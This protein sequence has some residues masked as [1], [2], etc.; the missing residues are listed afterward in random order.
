M[1]LLTALAVPERLAGL[2]VSGGSAR[3]ARADAVQRAIMA[4]LPAG[5]LVGMLKG[6]YSGGRPEHLAT[7]VDDL[8]RAGKQTLL[9]G[10]RELGSLNQE[11]GASRAVLP[12]PRG[13]RG[14]DP[15]LAEGRLIPAGTTSRPAPRSAG[16]LILITHSCCPGPDRGIS[17]S[18]RRA[19][20]PAS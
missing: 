5:A 2:V 4:L 7:A 11:F 19:G 1:A 3:A 14:Q 12:N 20:L 8:R 18:R 17:P 6:M 9:A 16:L 13:V 10:L 15:S